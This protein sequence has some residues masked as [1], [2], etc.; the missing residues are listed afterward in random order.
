MSAKTI[1]FYGA[2]L[3]VGYWVGRKY[4]SLLS[5]VPIIGS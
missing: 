5:G 2:I 3:V 4:P 1:L